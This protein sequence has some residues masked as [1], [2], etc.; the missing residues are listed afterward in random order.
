V[1]HVLRTEVPKN[2]DE[3]S[4]MIDTALQTAD[5]AV[6]AANHGTL[7]C[8]PGS[9]AFS[10][11]MIFDIFLIAD[12]EVIRHRRQQLVDKRARF[13]NQSRIY[14]DYNIGERVLIRNPDP[15]KLD[16][17]T[18]QNP[19]TITR[20]YTNGTVTIQRGLHV[21]KRINIR[22]LVPYRE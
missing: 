19:F 4:H 18:G 17:R 8:S 7:R 22:R 20:V 2:I 11:D 16:L 3:A 9:L 6:Q 21:T 10:R 13:T 14:H 12:M 15:S 5:Y 1:G